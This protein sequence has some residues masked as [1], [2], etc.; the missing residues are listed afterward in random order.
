MSLLRASWLCLAG[1]VWLAVSSTG[2]LSFLG[3]QRAVGT[4]AAP[5]RDKAARPRAR[6]IDDDELLYSEEDEYGDEFDDDE[7]GDYME[8]DGPP[9]EVLD[10]WE[11]DEIAMA[12]LGQ[13]QSEE[14]HGKNVMSFRDVAQLLEVLG[15]ERE[16]F[17]SIFSGD[18]EGEEDFDFDDD[19]LEEEYDARAA[20]R[21]RGGG[22]GGGRGRDRGPQRGPPRGPPGRGGGGRGRRP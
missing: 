22:G 15:L 11:K 4:K 6:D 10:G 20:G 9:P 3:P 5:P 12:L 19:F 8:L 1:A 2:A 13:F 18:A 16:Q 7:D 17:V 14:H 21:G